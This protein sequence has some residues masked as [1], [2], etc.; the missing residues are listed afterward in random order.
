MLVQYTTRTRLG[1]AQRP[2]WGTGVVLATKDEAPARSAFLEI[3]MS[4]GK[5]HNEDETWGGAEAAMEHADEMQLAT[6]V[7]AQVREQYEAKTPQDIASRELILG[8]KAG[9]VW[10]DLHLYLLGV[11]GVMRAVSLVRKAVLVWKDLHR[12]EPTLRS[13]LRMRLRCAE[14]WRLKS[15]CLQEKVMHLRVKRSGFTYMLVQYAI[16]T[17]TRLCAW[18]RRSAPA[19]CLQIWMRIESL[20]Y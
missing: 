18:Y 9:L 17:R 8:M 15:T 20:A 3:D 1:V 16:T 5:V 4:T 19:L 13:L 11:L 14:H 10:K 6:M 7:M 2:R 12:S